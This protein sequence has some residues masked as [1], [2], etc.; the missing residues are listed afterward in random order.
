[1]EWPAHPP[2]EVGGDVSPTHMKIILD[3]VRLKAYHGFFF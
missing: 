1:M 3:M 2:L